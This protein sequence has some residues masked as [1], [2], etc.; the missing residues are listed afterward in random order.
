M[1][2]FHCIIV[3]DEPPAHTVLTNYISRLRFLTLD[4]SFYT[5]YDALEFLNQNHTDIMFLDIQ[6]NDASGLDMISALTSPPAVILTTAYSSFAMDAFNLGVVDYLLK[7][8]PFERFAKAISR[9]T[10]NYKTKESFEDKYIFIKTDGYFQKVFLSELIY[11]E[12]FGNFVKLHF[13]ENFIL[14]SETLQ[15]ML[16]LLPGNSFIRIHKSFVVNKNKVLKIHGNQVT[17]T[18]NEL[19]IGASYKDELLKSLNI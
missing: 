10:E 11:I 12:G 16:K 3:D 17:L 14:T 15:N 13:H 18:K 19:P 1:K 9:I 7:P 6:L 5:T 2:T 8:I 4:A